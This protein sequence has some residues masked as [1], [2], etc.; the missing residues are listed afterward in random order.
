MSFVFNVFSFA[1]NNIRMKWMVQNYTYL[2]TEPRRKKLSHRKT[3]RCK[4]NKIDKKKRY[5]HT[6]NAHN[7]LRSNGSS[8]HQQHI[9]S[10]IQINMHGY[11]NCENM[12]IIILFS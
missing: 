5:K 1:L 6:H 3:K 12:T 4:R 10:L 11:E 9:H 7:T 8:A 2:N